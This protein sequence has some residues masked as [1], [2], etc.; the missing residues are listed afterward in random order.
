[1]VVAHMFV[2]GFHPEVDIALL[3]DLLAKPHLRCLWLVHVS[4][5]SSKSNVT[6]SSDCKVYSTM[7][8]FIVVMVFDP[9]ILVTDNSKTSISG[10]PSDKDTVM[11]IYLCAILL[12][13]HLI[14]RGL[15]VDWGII[16]ALKKWFCCPGSCEPELSLGKP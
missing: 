5:A 3:A 8:F 12:P 7:W 6:I 9:R 4:S 2:G 11:I 16:T 10:M 13:I 15:L 1:M 14:Y